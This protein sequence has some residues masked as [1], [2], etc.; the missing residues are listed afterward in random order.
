MAS[1]DNRIDAASGDG[2]STKVTETIARMG[3]L[4]SARSGS[5]RRSNGRPGNTVFIAC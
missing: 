5:G 1:E 4:S 2:G 3:P